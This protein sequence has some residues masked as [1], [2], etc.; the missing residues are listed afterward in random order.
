MPGGFWVAPASRSSTASS[1]GVSGGN[2][3]GWPPVARPSR[4]HAP[5]RWRP[6]RCATTSPRWWPSSAWPTGRPPSPGPGTPA[7]RR[8]ADRAAARPIGTRAR[9]S[10]TPDPMCWLLH[11]PEEP[12]MSVAPATATAPT[13]VR[14]FRIAS[15]L[16]LAG[17]AVLLVKGLTGAIAADALPDAAFGVLYLTGIA[18]VVAAS[19]AVGALQRRW[20]LKVLVAVVG[21]AERG[22]LRAGA[23][24][25]GLGGGVG[26]ALGVPDGL[27]GF[28]VR[29][30]VQLVRD[31]VR[32]LERPLPDLAATADQV[33]TEVHERVVA[34]PARR[35][36]ADRPQV[37]RVTAGAGGAE[38]R[39]ERHDVV[40]R[41][42]AQRPGQQLGLARGVGLRLVAG[43][44]DQR[45]E[46]VGLHVVALQTEV[47]VEGP[48]LEALLHRGE[49][50]RGVRSVHQPV[51]VRQRQVHH[52]AD[53]DRLAAVRVGH[54]DRSLDHR[55]GAED[56]HL[57][58]VDDRRVE[59]GTPAA[60][61]GERERAA[62]QL[63]RGAV[64]YTH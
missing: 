34:H 7:S 51:V 9:A 35:Q 46:L 50:P 52:R 61:V 29:T 36:E 42:P 24:L 32:V 11:R 60:G 23:L 6:R 56:A 58:L 54:H 2:E 14:T 31:R 10:G 15:T 26:Q 5:W 33:G 40:R 41:Q 57:R 8:R 12:A 1:R 4:S 63:V 62:A 38:V 49:E 17:G 19:V 27:S 28:P 45:P 43:R 21:R 22:D 3:T 25:V 44:V 53:R 47:R 16:A 30:P 18:L 64:S 59:Q 48:L 37:P 39:V 13:S 55:A 20:P